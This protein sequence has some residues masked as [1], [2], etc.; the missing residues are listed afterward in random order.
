MREGVEDPKQKN[1]PSDFLYQVI[2][3]RLYLQPDSPEIENQWKEFSKSDENYRLYREK[4]SKVCTYLTQLWRQ[5]F[6]YKLHLDEG[7]E[8][9]SEFLGFLWRYLLEWMGEGE[10]LPEQKKYD[11]NKKA[12]DYTQ[13]FQKKLQDELCAAIREIILNSQEP[14]LPDFS[15]GSL[16]PLDE[17]Y[18]QNALTQDTKQDLDV[19]VQSLEEDIHQNQTLEN[20]QTQANS[21]LQEVVLKQSSPRPKLQPEENSQSMQSIGQWKYL[22]VSDEIDRHTDSH[23]KSIQLSEDLS[24]IGARVRGKKHKHDGTNCDD[25]FEFRTTG[26]WTIIA[27]S[28]GAGSKKFS[29]IGAKL[30]CEAAVTQLSSDLKSHEL[31][32]R[33]SLNEWEQ[34]LE[35]NKSWDFLC[36]DINLVQEALHNAMRHSLK[37]IDKEVKRVYDST[38]Y[39]ELNDHRRPE[40]GDF[41]ATLL[42]AVHTSVNCGGNTFDFVLTCQVG[43]GML[44]A[45]HQRGNLYLL[46]KPDSGEHAGQTDF[47]TSKNKLDEANLKQKTFAF[48]NPLKALMVMTDGVADDYFPNNPGMLNLYGDLVLNQVIEIDKP[49]ESSINETLEKTRLRNLASVRVAEERFR[50]NFERILGDDLT[51]EPREVYLRSTA[52]YA[53][54]LE[55]PIEEIIKSPELLGAGASGDPMWHGAQEKLP[56]E[57]L[58]VWLDSYYKRGS[59]D[60]RTLV[61]LY[62][63][64]RA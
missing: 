49:E 40:I 61:I 9:K 37:V 25:W 34:A 45:I 57:R 10:N 54:E 60:D 32:E 17:N 42:L 28:D 63:G 23:A 31:C 58:K 55:K 48:F 7:E 1:Y 19:G 30:A 6:E 47:I 24:I 20:Q 50:E 33:S 18:K 11:L 26:D 4:A 15:Q 38:T 13:L 43:D 39:F 44:A 46:G 59:F 22:P 51:D 29:R 52:D 8:V 35:R 5:A 56:Q 3:W 21:A 53:K 12:E 36:Q 64:V 27:V 14:K 41:S 2:C 16:K 62:Q